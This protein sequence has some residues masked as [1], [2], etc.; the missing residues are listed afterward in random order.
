[1]ADKK[2]PYAPLTREEIEEKINEMKL[3]LQLELDPDK[4]GYHR[5]VL[6]GYEK[7]L[8]KSFPRTDNK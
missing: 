8:E 5:S 4:R 6:K 2:W 7:M 1:M 3:L